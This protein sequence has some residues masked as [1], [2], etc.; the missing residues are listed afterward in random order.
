LSRIKEDDPIL[1]AT[2]AHLS[3]F[4][5]NGLRTLCCAYRVLPDD[6]FSAWMIRYNDANCS[7]VGREEALQT[8]L[9]EV[10]TELSLLGVT[11][12]EDKLQVGVPDAIES[13]LQAKINVWV[14]TGDK[15][16]TAI[17]IGFACALL[18]S[19]MELI[20]LD[21]SDI[22]ELINTMN[23]GDQSTSSSKGLIASGQ[24]LELL[25]T[26]D[27]EDQFLQLSLKCQSVICCRMTPKQKADIV[28]IMRKK[29][30][31]LALAIGDGA[32]DVPMIKEADVGV[33][34]SGKE[35]MQA[36]QSSDYSIAQF[37]FLKP[38]LLFHGRLSFYRN[39]D[40]VFYSFYKNIA[41]SFNQVIYTFMSSFS[42]NTMY[43][44]PLYTVF[45][46]F[47]TSIP[48]FIFASLDRDVDKN[49]M[50]NYPL[51]Y[52]FDGRRDWYQS[53]S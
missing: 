4:A 5:E 49:S 18:S 43:D 11:A 50:L 31:K 33:G 51:L 8:V 19:G 47:F 52:D 3:D 48:P 6:F 16:E 14:I 9:A 44:G 15:R 12:I 13:L 45:N 27:H 10:E 29:T 32:N 37:R 24:A 41:L 1:S 22:N 21:S 36:V 17:N 46:V 7:I 28:I 30:G 42:G 23:E 26:E 39:T 35:G 53:F 2:K 40:C 25:L 20:T 38:L 34:I